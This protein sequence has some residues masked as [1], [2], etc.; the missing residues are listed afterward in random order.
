M[1]SICKFSLN[2]VKPKEP[3]MLTG[4]PPKWY[5]V[6]TGAVVSPVADKITT[7][8]IEKHLTH[9]VTSIEHGKPVVLP[10]G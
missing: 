9:P 1:G 3:K 2:V 7:G 4:S 8:G 5:V 10:T 6:G